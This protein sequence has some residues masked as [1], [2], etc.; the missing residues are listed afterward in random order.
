MQTIT[1]SKMDQVLPATS[2][3]STYDS[4]IMPE[5]I[6]EITADNLEI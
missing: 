4:F 6:K 5:V 1:S 2:M 3:S